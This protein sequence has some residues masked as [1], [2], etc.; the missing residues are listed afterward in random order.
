MFVK[1]WTDIY[2]SMGQLFLYLQ[3]VGVGTCHVGLFKH[4]CYLYD[5]CCAQQVQSRKVPCQAKAPR[6]QIFLLISGPPI[7]ISPSF[8]RSPRLRET[9]EQLPQFR[10]PVGEFHEWGALQHAK[11][12]EDKNWYPDAALHSTF[13]AQGTVTFSRQR[14][15]KRN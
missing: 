14:K 3:R 1:R 10:D 7:K 2:C 13:S 6:V 15:T 5:N 4:D 8:Q 11:E 12:E 9:S